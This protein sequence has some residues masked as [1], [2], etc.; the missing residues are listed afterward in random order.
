VGGGGL[1]AF[2]LGFAGRGGAVATGTVTQTRPIHNP[3]PQVDLELPAALSGGKFVKRGVDSKPFGAVLAVRAVWMPSA[4]TGTVCVT[5]SP[6]PLLWIIERSWCQ[7][8]EKKTQIGS[9]A[10]CTHPG[11]RGEKGQYDADDCASWVE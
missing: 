8:N 2:F 11:Q 10:P 6:T 7:W 1:P 5:A 4:G 9:I 3:P